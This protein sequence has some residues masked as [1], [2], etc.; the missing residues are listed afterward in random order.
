MKIGL[1]VA[2]TGV[3]VMVGS[4]V[5]AFADGPVFTGTFRYVAED[6]TTATVFVTPCGA[7]CAH[8][9]SDTGIT[10]VQARLV[11]GQWRYS[12]VYPDEYACADGSESPGTRNVAI[13][14]ATFHGTTTWGPDLACG[15]PGYLGERYTFTL[16]QI[17]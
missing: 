2:A 10:D 9:V 14:A 16:T 6:G 3:G 8:I 12:Q 7:G 5:P 13:D 17:G 15:E 4:P 11:D 1:F